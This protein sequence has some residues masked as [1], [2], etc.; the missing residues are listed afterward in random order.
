VWQL[1]FLQCSYLGLAVHVSPYENFLADTKQKACRDLQPR[2]SLRLSPCTAIMSQLE[3]Q[4]LLD[5]LKS[6]S[7]SFFS[8]SYSQGWVLYQEY[9]MPTLR[10]LLSS[11]PDITSLF[12]LLITLYVSLMVL[13]TASRWMYSLVL[14][15][16]RMLFMMAL[17]LGALWVI[18]VGQGEDGPE[19]V[20]GGI[21]SAMDKGKQ[22]I[23]DVMGE[24]FQR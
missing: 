13:N 7:I 15:I 10:S 6:Y 12:L 5:Y 14:G 8:E 1:S 9:V 20:K 4:S 16:I 24:F 22:Y 2:L 19:A 18:R 11:H 17:V 23:W 3:L 21:Q